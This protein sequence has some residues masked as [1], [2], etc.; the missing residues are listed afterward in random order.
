MNEQQRRVA[1]IGHILQERASD[2]A[3]ASRITNPQD[4][5]HALALAVVGIEDV[6]AML[7]KEQREAERQTGDVAPWETGG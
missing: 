7:M 2:L 6:K 5:A 4:M 3:H 1:E